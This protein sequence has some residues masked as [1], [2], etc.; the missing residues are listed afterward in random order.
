M[1][2]GHSASIVRDGLVMYYDVGNTQRSYKGKPTANMVSAGGIDMSAIT[3]YT[4]TTATRVNEPLSPSGYALESQA[5]AGYASSARHWFGDSSLITPT[6]G[7]AFFSVY[8]KQTAGPTSLIPSTYTGTQ[9]ITLAPLD[10]GS[11]YLSPNYRRFGVYSTYGTTSSGPTMTVSIFQASVPT[12]SDI[13]R[14]HSPQMEIQTYVTPFVNGSRSVTQSLYDLTGNTTSDMTNATYDSSGNISYAAAGYVIS[15]ENSLLNTQTPTVEVWAKPTTLNQGASGGFFFE[16][17]NVNT[18]YSLFLDPSGYLRW[19]IMCPAMV[20]LVILA[21]TAGVVTTAYNHIVA[22]YISGTG[23]RLYIN[24][25]LIAQDTQS[26]TITTN[27]N[28]MSIGVYGG[29]N[30]ARG[31]YYNG[32]LDIVRVYN[33]AL[34]ATEVM[35]NF[36]AHRGRFGL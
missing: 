1:S 25:A 29:Y 3:G 6:T 18:Q 17:G 34:S 4:L 10:G 15:P 13:A 20:D 33:K 2:L 28:G 7:S 16:K 24:G 36:N 31:Y 30:G 12:T 22:T 11:A 35:Q 5:Q 14:W 21:S 8:A 26:G 9:W 19:R 27:A 23:S 32:G